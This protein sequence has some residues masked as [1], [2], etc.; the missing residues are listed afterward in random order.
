MHPILFKIGPVTIYSYGFVVASAFLLGSWLILREA[1]R[2]GLNVE[3]VLDVLVAILFGGL[4]GG[5]LLYVIIN[6]GVYL[7]HPLR[8]FMVSEG[9]MAFHGGLAGGIAGAV[10]ASK[11]RKQSLPV[12]LDLMSPYVALGHAIG[13]VGC[14][15]NGCCYG[16]EVSGLGL[17]F[18]GE[19]VMRSP[20]QLYESL[21]LLALFL[22]LKTVLEHRKFHGQVFAIYLMLYAV[23]R[24]LTES[25][26]GDVPEF[27]PGL[28]LARIISIG[29]FFCGS[30]L[31]VWLCNR[32]S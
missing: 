24:F 30:A 10:I 11:I 23:L 22:V 20:V 28:T 29:I 4:I 25:F 13:R 16:K 1:R 6:Y 27:L 31:Y 8:V 26:R 2:E 14:L 7:E 3:T 17:V 21:T 12:I 5:R 9:G 15:L 18:P 19:T 32:R